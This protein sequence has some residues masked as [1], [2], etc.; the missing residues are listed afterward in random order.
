MSTEENKAVVR[1]EFEEMFNSGGNLGAAEDFYAP[2][3]VGHEP[4]AGDVRGIEGAR[5]FA[6]NYRA[7]FPDLE[8][9]IEDQLAEGDKVVTRFS[10]RGTHQGEI[11]DLGP[12]TGNRMEVMGITIERFAQGK[13]VEDWSTFDALGMMQQVGLVPE[14]GHAEV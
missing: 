7:A 14:P 10:V 1:R 2:D 13:I 3:Y 9:T 5:Q 6:E 12:A 8:A 11:E 4:T